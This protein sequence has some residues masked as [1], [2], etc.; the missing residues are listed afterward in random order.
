MVKSLGLL[1]VCI[2][3]HKKFKLV[4]GGRSDP[5]PHSNMQEKN[6]GSLGEVA[7]FQTMHGRS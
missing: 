2:Q 6:T 4:G 5:S 7:S 1:T 3:M